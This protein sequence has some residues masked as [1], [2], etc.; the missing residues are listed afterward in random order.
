MR[1]HGPRWEG[2][3]VRGRVGAEDSDPPPGHP[4]RYS[5]PMRRSSRTVAFAGMM[6]VLLV[7]TFTLVLLTT[8]DGSIDVNARSLD[9]FLAWTTYALALVTAGLLV[10]AIVAGRRIGQQIAEG[11]EQHEQQIAA[12]TRPAINVSSASLEDRGVMVTI[13]NI[14]VGPAFGIT[15]TAWLLPMDEVEPSRYDAAETVVGRAGDLN[16]QRHEYVR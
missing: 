10:A 11:R 3:G 16:L 9:A 7:T 6:S 5:F 1:T 13:K 2:D 12:L 4:R 15:V 14:G 8:L